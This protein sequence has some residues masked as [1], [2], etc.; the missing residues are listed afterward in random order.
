[1]KKTILII[2]LIL[3]TAYLIF[4]GEATE[5]PI[6]P[7]IISENQISVLVTII[8]GAIIRFI[9]LKVRKLRNKK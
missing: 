6:N 8:V 5:S 2:Y 1:M 3:S 9:E 4:A 7:D